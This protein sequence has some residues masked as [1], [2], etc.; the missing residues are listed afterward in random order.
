M[1]GDKIFFSIKNN[2]ELIE[3]K[4]IND[5]IKSKIKLHKVDEEGNPLIGVKFD[6]YDKEDNYLGTYETDNEGDIEL[7]LEYGVYYFI[8]KEAIPTYELNSDKQYFEVTKDGEVIEL[9][10]VNIKV[11]DTLVSIDYSFILGGILLVLKK[12]HCNN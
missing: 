12:K 4:V 2:N 3:L 11:P 1:N 9:S 8:E 10:V 7:E 6:L 5:I